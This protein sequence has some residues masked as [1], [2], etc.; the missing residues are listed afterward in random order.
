MSNKALGILVVFLGLVFTSCKGDGDVSTKN[1]ELSEMVFTK[2]TFDFGAV[3]QGDIVS[4]TFEFTNSGKNDLIITEAVGSCGCTVPDYPKDVINP[5]EKGEI[6]VS[7]NS[8][9]KSGM[10][11]KTVMLTVN[12]KN[13]TEVLNI[14]ANVIPRIGIAQ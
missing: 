6:K 4:T 10:Q 14:K 7:F 11:H 2:N 9:G 8:T 12:T 13:G 1:G 3:N 5:G